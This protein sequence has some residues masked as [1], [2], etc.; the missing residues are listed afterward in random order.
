MRADRSNSV[1]VF[2]VEYTDGSVRKVWQDA[3]PKPHALAVAAELDERGCRPVIR[4]LDLT[5]AEIVARSRAMR[6]KAKA[7]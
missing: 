3:L 4:R 2:L 1:S 7:P 6:P 5:R